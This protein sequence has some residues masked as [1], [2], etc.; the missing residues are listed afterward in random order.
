LTTTGEKQQVCFCGDVITEEIPCLANVESWNLTLGGDLSVNFVVDVDESIADTAKVLVSVAGD[1]YS[2][3]A[4]EAVSV[5][6]AA[7]QMNDEINVQIVNGEDVSAVK[8]YT[9]LQYAQYV[10]AD[11]SLSDY[12]QMVKEML[13]YGGYAQIYFGYNDENP[14]HTGIEG[15]GAAEVP[16]DAAAEMEVVGKVSGIS[17]YGASLLFRNKIAVRY[18]FNVSGDVSGYTFTVN[19]T[20]YQPELKE[21]GLYYIEVADINPQDLDDAITVAVNE[22]LTVSYSPMNYIVRMSTKGSENLQALMKAIYNYHLAA[23]VICPDAE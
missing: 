1:E 3:D 13:N 7:A 2:Y 18:Y 17:F 12:H 9:V 21:E 10:L 22:T 14:V 15:V 20:E 23:E 6:V 11:E 16:A 5:N 19:G 8:T 4:T